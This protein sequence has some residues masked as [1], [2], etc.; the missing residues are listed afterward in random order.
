MNL[1]FGDLPNF[2]SGDMIE[3]HVAMAISAL[4]G[5]TLT[6]ICRHICLQQ[7]SENSHTAPQ[8]ICSMVMFTLKKM[9]DKL[10][11]LR[12]AEDVRGVWKFITIPK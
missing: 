1:S 5:G 4:Q 3:F 6:Q 11:P 10:S 9:R 2:M 7:L 8:D 12:V